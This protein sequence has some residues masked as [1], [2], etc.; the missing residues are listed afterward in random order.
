MSKVNILLESCKGIDHCGICLFVCPKG[1]FSS[2]E[3]MN[4]AGYFPP[5]ITDEDECNTCQNCMICCPDFAIVVEKG[6]KAS[7]SVPEDDDE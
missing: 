1:L 7:E 6:D 4:S 2:S 3:K 5:E